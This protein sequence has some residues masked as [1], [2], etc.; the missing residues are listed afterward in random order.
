MTCDT[1]IIQHT[2]SDETCELEGLTSVMVSDVL[3]IGKKKDFR[4]T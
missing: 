4:T 2:A 3:P 1:A